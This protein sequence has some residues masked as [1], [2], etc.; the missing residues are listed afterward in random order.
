MI[1]TGAA[2]ADPMEKPAAPAETAAAP[3]GRNPQAGEP[4]K[5]Q[6]RDMFSNMADGFKDLFSGKTSFSDITEGAK[7]FVPQAEVDQAQPGR[8]PDPPAVD[9][10][11]P[12]E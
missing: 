3:I 1:S 4:S 7:L 5:A 2:H 10:G 8:P 9:N 12:D 6:T 11:K